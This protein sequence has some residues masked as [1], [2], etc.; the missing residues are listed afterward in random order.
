MENNVFTKIDTFLNAFLTTI[1]QKIQTLLSGEIGTLLLVSITLYIVIYGYMVLAGKVQTPLSDLMWNLARFAIIIAFIK[2]EGGILNSFNDAVKELSTIGGNGKSVLG[3]FDDLL[4]ATSTYSDYVGGKTSW[5]AEWLTAT[6]IWVG[7]GLMTIP[8]ALTFLLSKITLYFLLAL[9]PIFFFMLMW[10]WLKDSF[11]Q[12]ASALLSNALAMIC[13]NVMVQSSIDFLQDQMNYAGNPFL[14]S[15]AFLVMGLI[16]GMAIKYMV[17][18]V[19]S[20]MRVSVERAGAG[21]VGAYK[22]AKNALLSPFTPTANAT[23]MATQRAATSQVE[24][25]KALQQLIQNLNKNLD[26][27]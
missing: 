11:A 25:Q 17:G 24:T 1:V 18:V 23:Q 14:T 21:V 22:G 3:L 9:S 19:N 15:F 16:A 2:N 20:V 26:G 12:Y 13:M 8:I 5:S 6:L 4:E 7:F 27:K 10:G